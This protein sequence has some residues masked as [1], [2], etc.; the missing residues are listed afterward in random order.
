MHA[1]YERVNNVNFAISINI[2]STNTVTLDTI[3]ALQK[4]RVH[5]TKPLDLLLKS[6]I[7]HCANIYTIGMCEQHPRLV[8]RQG[9]PAPE[10]IVSVPKGMRGIG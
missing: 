10:G 3:S 7:T 2:V 1:S 8:V 4:P 5:A 6:I 9:A